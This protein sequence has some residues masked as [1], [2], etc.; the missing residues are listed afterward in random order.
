M[1]CDANLMNFGQ[2]L[3]LTNLSVFTVAMGYCLCGVSGLIVADDVVR[4]IIK[5]AGKKRS[6]QYDLWK[7]IFECGIQSHDAYF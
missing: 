7:M 4:M 5:V 1:K 2:N 6:I 3:K